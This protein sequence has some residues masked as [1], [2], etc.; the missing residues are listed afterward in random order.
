MPNPNAGRVCVT[1]LLCCGA[2][3]ADDLPAN[4]QMSVELIGDQ[5]TLAKALES[6]Q[7]RE[8]LGNK[9]IDISLATPK[10]FD[11]SRLLVGCES[12]QVDPLPKPKP[13][14][15]PCIAT[16]VGDELV[17]EYDFRISEE[18]LQKFFQSP[19]QALPKI[20]GKYYL[21][22][23]ELDPK[24]ADFLRQYLKETCEACAVQID[25][26]PKPKP[27]PKPRC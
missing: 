26:K 20:E 15:K 13:I 18:D 9:P 16:G 27:L 4:K 1:L 24:N 22:L 6:H 23:R 17:F 7:V 25:P 12:C 3:H 2:A 10:E 14:P 21:Q 8:A 19:P 5:Q 11:I